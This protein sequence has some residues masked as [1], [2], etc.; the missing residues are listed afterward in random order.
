MHM[1]FNRPIM[2]SLWWSEQTVKH[3]SQKMRLSRTL[4][5]DSLQEGEGAPQKASLQEWTIPDV[6]VSFGEP[7]GEGTAW[8]ISTTGKLSPWGHRRGWGHQNPVTCSLTGGPPEVYPERMAVRA[9]YGEAGME[10]DERSPDLLVLLLSHLPF[11]GPNPAHALR[12]RPSSPVAQDAG[13]HREGW[14]VWFCFGRSGG[15][16]FANIKLIICL[17]SFL[18][19]LLT[20]RKT[21]SS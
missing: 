1:A 19:G 12:C 6:S 10:R 21:L 16:E 20:L 2:M 4:A 17:F 7:K 9:R 3:W 5:T 14:E 13:Q 11:P 18:W 8:S 15:R